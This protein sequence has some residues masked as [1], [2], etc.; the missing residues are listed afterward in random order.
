[1]MSEE[2]WPN[3]SI[4]GEAAIAFRSRIGHHL[5]GLPERGSWA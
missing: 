2:L 4:A 3:Q 1:M 5:H